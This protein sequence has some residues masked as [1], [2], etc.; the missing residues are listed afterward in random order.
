MEKLGAHLRAASTARTER[1]R[2]GTKRGRRERKNRGR[3]TSSVT[4][5]TGRKTGIVTEGTSRSIT[6]WIGLGPPPEPDARL[7]APHGQ[8]VLVEREMYIHV[9]A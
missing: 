3:G 5:R 9:D 4:R 2:K 7:A 6:G 1:R 8:P